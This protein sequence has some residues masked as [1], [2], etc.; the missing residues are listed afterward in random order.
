MIFTL[1]ALWL[2][3]ASVSVHAADTPVNFR[4]PVPQVEKLPNGLTLAWFL[5]DRIP[6]VDLGLLVKT[7]FLDDP[8]NKSGTAELLSVLLDRGAGG[9][10]AND[11]ARAV[12][13]LGAT[14]YA[15]SD[16]DSFS[17]GMHGLAPD[18]G[19]L[20]DLLALMALKPDFPE[21]EVKREHARTLDRWSHLGESADWMA[22][23]AFRRIIT[24]GTE[25]GRGSFVSASQ[26]KNVTRDD[27]VAFHK[28]Y[29]TPANSV[30]MIV[31]RVDQAAFRAKIL[32]K[33][34]QPFGD[35]TP[36]K[37][38]R[39]PYRDPRLA[40]AKD[41]I[42]V[43]NRPGLTQ[44]EV[45]MGFKAPKFDS[46][47]HYSLVVANALLGEYF[48][49]RLNALVRDKLGLT[50]AIASGFS[51]SRD[52]GTFLI[53]TAGKN[54]T[55]GQLV[56]RSVEVVR[57]LRKGPIPGEEVGMAKD[58]LIGGFPIS[59]STLGA[60]AARW[61]GGYILNLGPEFLN[62]FVPRVRKVE[63]PDVITAVGRHLDPS[64]LRI[65]IV[66]DLKEITP[67]LKAAGFANLKPVSV[68][69]LQ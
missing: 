1:G 61:L 7:G 55:V 45:R 60:V 25:Y 42:L 59:T 14:R 23:L 50:Y 65:V 53:S 51:Y 9:K 30:L 24:A 49:S 28:R 35:P 20:L 34:G 38:T 47:D 19:T 11:I 26:F 68:R 54:E 32:E 22:N 37:S 13:S 67:S 29:F 69:D 17:V 58:Y 39:K 57:D 4:L 15:S 36:P 2:G 52:F 46:P 18:A 63:A 41:Q 5:D 6:V 48:N 66:G 8:T 56:R 44:A 12:E 31:G 33:F 43:I 40:L 64:A 62:E 27:L 10:S 3:L 16:E 21:A